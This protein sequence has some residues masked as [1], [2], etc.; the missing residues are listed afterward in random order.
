[1][2]A[3]YE[4]LDKHPT[5][6][7]I[8]ELIFGV[9]MVFVPFA[10]AA[11][12]AQSSQPNPDWAMFKSDFSE[13]FDGGELTL[14]IFGS[15][16]SVLWASFIKFPRT[17]M[18]SKAFLLI[19]SLIVTL[20]V[21]GVIGD[22]IGF[23]QILPSWLLS[24]LAILYIVILGIHLLLI[25]TTGRTTSEPGSSIQRASELRNRARAKYDG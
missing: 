5:L 20:L 23:K 3:L 2:R 11:G 22:N 17:G 18:I 7:D 13:Y 15:I 19:G 14:V 12:L 10:V 21:G 1:M 4:W 9:L 16:A 24:S 6:A 8:L 25:F